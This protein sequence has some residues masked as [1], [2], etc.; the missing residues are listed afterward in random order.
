[1]ANPPT[2][3]SGQCNNNSNG[4]TAGLEELNTPHEGFLWHL[5]RAFNPKERVRDGDVGTEGATAVRYHGRGEREQEGRQGP[6]E[7]A[8]NEEA[9]T[10]HVRG[11]KKDEAVVVL[12]IHGEKEV[13]GYTGG[14]TVQRH[15]RSRAGEGAVVKG[16]S[17]QAAVEGGEN[18]SSKGS[19]RGSLAVDAVQLEF[20]TCFRRT[21]E[22]RAN[23]AEAVS[24]AI[25]NHLQQEQKN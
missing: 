2:N 6:E 15:A 10:K 8:A 17:T 18:E 16:R 5:R 20:G 14:Y 21:P 9:T 11:G 7:E 3:K 13:V 22:A 24:C 25:F 4:K 23:A 12:P 19:N 1:M